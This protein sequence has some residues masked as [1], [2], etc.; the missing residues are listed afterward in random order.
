MSSFEEYWNKY[1]SARMERRN[2]ILE[3]TLHTD[4]QSLRWDFCRMASCRSC[5]TRSAPTATTA[6]SY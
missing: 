1:Q 2:G 3:V 6:S 5:S 4:G